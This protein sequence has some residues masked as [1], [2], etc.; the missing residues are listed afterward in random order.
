MPLW[1]PA[2]ACSPRAMRDRRIL[3]RI[4]IRKVGHAAKFSDAE[5]SHSK[6]RGRRG[7]VAEIACPRAESR[8]CVAIP[9]VG[10]YRRFQQLANLLRAFQRNLRKRGEHPGTCVFALQGNR[11][12]GCFEGGGGLT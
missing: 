6:R 9:G 1:D 10:R 12:A 7:I 3:V 5:C 2:F 11:R 4:G 8:L